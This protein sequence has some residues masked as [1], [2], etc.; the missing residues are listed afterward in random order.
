MFNRK[1]TV[2]LGVISSAS[3]LFILAGRSSRAEERGGEDVPDV[4]EA[5]SSSPSTPL[6]MLANEPVV[7]TDS[8]TELQKL[9][10][11][12]YNI[13]LQMLRTVEFQH[14]RGIESAEA[15]FEAARRVTEAEIELSDDPQ[16]KIAALEKLLEI[17]DRVERRQSELWKAGRLFESGRLEARYERLSIEIRLLRAR[18]AAAQKRL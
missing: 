2:L 5:E 9:L 17:A 18:E 1:V 12:R 8:D 15:L 14:S 6:R 13:A 4:K 11:T 16:R 7:I 3:V 10:K